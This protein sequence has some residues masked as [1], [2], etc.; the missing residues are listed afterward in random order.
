MPE[1]LTDQQAE[2]LAGNG[3]QIKALPWAEKA[4][5]LK[6]AIGREIELA[7]DVNDLAG[8][9]HCGAVVQDSLTILFYQADDHRHLSAGIRQLAN[10]LGLVDSTG[11]TAGEMQE[12]IA[13]DRELGKEE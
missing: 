2:L 12:A 3:S 7:M 6:D 4:A 11:D 9:E 13:G 10:C 5:L 1:I 8:P